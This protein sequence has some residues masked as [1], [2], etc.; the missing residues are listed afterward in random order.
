[1]GCQRLRTYEVDA[2]SKRCEFYECALF[3]GAVDRVLT[4]FLHTVTPHHRH[5]DE[6]TKSTDI[7][8]KGIKRDENSVCMCTQNAESSRLIST[9]VAYDLLTE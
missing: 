1:M 5:S 8:A 9:T 3:S 7:T 6:M 4:S 2:Q